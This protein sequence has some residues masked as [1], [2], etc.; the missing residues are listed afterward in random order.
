MPSERLASFDA[1]LVGGGPLAREVRSEAEARGIRVVQTYGMSETCGGCV[2]DGRPLDGVE[3]RI[4][5]DEVQLRGPVLF[6]GYEGEPERT[7]AVMKDGWFRTDDLGR[8][9][10]DG[11]LVGDREGRRRDHQW[12]REGARSGGGGG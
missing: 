3:V 5:D 10:D 7:A 4:E 2:Y 1:V 8:L 11:R 6:E 12:R 9:D